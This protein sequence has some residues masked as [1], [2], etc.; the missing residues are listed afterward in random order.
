[1]KNTQ[2]SFPLWNTKIQP[3]ALLYISATIK[4]YGSIV[5]VAA[6]MFEK[7][8]NYWLHCEQSERNRTSLV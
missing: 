8:P 2:T 5:N 3:T 6:H 7:T 1:M 4:Q